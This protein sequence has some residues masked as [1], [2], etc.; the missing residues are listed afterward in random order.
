LCAYA[1]MRVAMPSATALMACATVTLGAVVL[2][3]SLLW[4]DR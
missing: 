1:I 4:R 3:V 2:L